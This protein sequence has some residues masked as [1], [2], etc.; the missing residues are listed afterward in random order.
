MQL[1]IPM[2]VSLLSSDRSDNIL[3]EELLEAIGFENIELV[4]DIVQNRNAI[5]ELVSDIIMFSYID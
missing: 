5:A 3:S 1:L 4:G 2:I